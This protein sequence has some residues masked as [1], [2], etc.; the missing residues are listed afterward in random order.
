MPWPRS[1]VASSAMPGESEA[2]VAAP[3]SAASPPWVPV[4]PPVAEAA[5]PAARRERAAPAAPPK[6]GWA[7]RIAFE[8]ASSTAISISA[9]ASGPNPTRRASSTT[10]FRIRPRKYVSRG[11]PSETRSGLAALGPN[12]LSTLRK[13]E[14]SPGTHLF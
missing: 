6:A 8:Q 11:T 7:C 4:P 1:A 12:G 9:V 5:A 13:D 3:A 2:A 14:S 10:V